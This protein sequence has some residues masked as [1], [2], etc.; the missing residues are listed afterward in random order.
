MLTIPGILVVLFVVD[1]FTR[2]HVIGI[3][4]QRRLLSKLRNRRAVDYSFCL[5]GHELGPT[6]LTFLPFDFVS[7][8]A[9]L[10]KTHLPPPLAKIS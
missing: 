5:H 1:F 6:A 8:V 4:S 10:L 7:A 2:F 3:D 9:N